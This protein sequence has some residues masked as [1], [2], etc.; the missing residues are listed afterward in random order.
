M[1]IAVGACFF[2]ERDVDVNSGHWA[3]VRANVIIRMCFCQLPGI[4]YYF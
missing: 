3:K 4:L 1:E 2:A